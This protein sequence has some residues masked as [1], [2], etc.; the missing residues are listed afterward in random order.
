M[1]VIDSFLFGGRSL[2]P[3]LGEKNFDLLHGDIRRDQDLDRALADVHHVV[4]LAAIVG[5]PACAREPELARQTNLEASRRL[6]GKAIEN[7][8]GRLIFASTCS[9]YGKMNDPNGYVDETS[10]LQPVSYYAE[11]KVEFERI[12]LSLDY[13]DFTPTVLR[14]ATAYGLSPRPRFDLTVNEFTRE[15]TLGRKLEVFGEQFWR[16]YAHTRDLVRAIMLTLTGDRAMLSGQAFNIGDTVENYQKKTIVR[17]ILEQLP[18]ARENV[19]Y[20]KRDE[21]PRDYRVN[22]DKVRTRLGFEL[23]RTVPDG[24]RE[25]IYAIRSGLIPDPDSPLYRNSCPA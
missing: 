19:S 2:L 14:F 4:H 18:G 10:P 7:G 16:P 9:N 17:L 15:L 21:D 22:F 3:Y 1:R 11:L 13:H 24:I 8:V 25:I 12:L 6:L 23:S 5:D 20:V